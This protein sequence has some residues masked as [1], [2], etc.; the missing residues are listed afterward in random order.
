MTWEGG[1]IYVCNNNVSSLAARNQHPLENQPGRSRVQQ[2]VRCKNVELN[3][4]AGKNYVDVLRQ[5]QRSK[6]CSREQYKSAD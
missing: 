4:S 6:K 1:G 5:Q 2:L 3:S